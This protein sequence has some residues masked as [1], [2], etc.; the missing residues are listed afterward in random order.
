MGNKYFRSNNIATWDQANAASQAVGGELVEIDDFAENEF[1]RIKISSPV[2]IG[3]ND[4]A[5]E[6]QLEWSNGEP[7]SFNNIEV[8]NFCSENTANNDYLILHPWDGKWSYTNGTNAKNYIMEIDCENF[9]PPSTGGGNGGGSTGG[10]S[11]SCDEP[12]QGFT[13]I[14]ELGGKQYFISNGANEW[15]DAKILTEAQGGHLVVINDAAENLFIKNR[16][17]EMIHLGLSDS[18]V[19]GQLE[20]VDGTPFDY[21]NFQICNFCQGNSPTH[22]NVIMHQWDGGWSYQT[23]AQSRRYIMERVCQPNS[24]GGSTGGGGTTGGGGGTS[25]GC[26]DLSVSYTHLTLPTNREV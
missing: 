11:N 14:G 8:C 12:V 25:T 19:E 23:N 7:L 3:L 18:A 1:L 22:D 26:S 6:G 10:T 13:P 20:W 24:G 9:T 17:T 21:D 4:A 16:I 5:S 2:L 15:E